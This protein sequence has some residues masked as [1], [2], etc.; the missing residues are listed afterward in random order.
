MIAF[1]RPS[2]ASAPRR[3]RRL[4]AAAAGLLLAARA[5]A[6]TVDGLRTED[7]VCPLG[8][9]TPE[10]RLSW[11]LHADQRAQT[12]SA[13]HLMVASSARELAAAAL[14]TALSF[15]ACSR[16]TPMGRVASEWRRTTNGLAPRVR[17]PVNAT[18]RI[19]LPVSSDAD[20]LE[21]GRPARTAPP[22]SARCA[23]QRVPC[24][25]R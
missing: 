19:H 3:L 18:T 23:G 21:S 12:Q 7:G 16:Q 22:V 2:F 13:Y 1:V 24:R 10:P 11:V 4:S 8:L 14:P 25:L 15:V 17:V 5:G 20:V 9:D 6:M